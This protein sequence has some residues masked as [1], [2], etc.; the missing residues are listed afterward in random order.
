M[1]AAKESFASKGFDK[2]SF[3][4][5]AKQSGVDPALVHHYFASKD[6]LFLESLDIPFDPRTLVAEWT[7]DGV[8]QLGVQIA[9]RF[10]EVWDNPATR[11]PIETLLRSAA[12]SDAVADMLRSGLVRLIFGP[13]GQAID[14]P[15]AMLRA[16]LVASQL[17]GMGM[18]RYI[19]ALEPLA[20]T[21]REEVIA[22]LAP[23]LQGYL[24]GP[25]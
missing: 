21:P 5:V 25:I 20:S 15:D 18:A 12:S 6:D 8:D 11:L 9:T 4:G 16:Q 22:R 3:R 1:A 2:T 17:V 23:V 7:S 10:L 19:L 14:S 13:I 24:T